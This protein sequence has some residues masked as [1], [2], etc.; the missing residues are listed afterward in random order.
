M[1]AIPPSAPPDPHVRASDGSLSSYRPTRADQLRLTEYPTFLHPNFEADAFAHAV[2]NGEDYP[3]PAEGEAPPTGA[4]AGGTGFMKGLVGENGLGDVSAA[5]ARLNFGIEDLNRQLKG[6][7]TKHH[8]SLL[9]QA[10]SLGGLDNDLSEVRRGLAEVEGGVTRLQRKI[11]TP[12]Q[13]LASSL[14]LLT[15]LRRAASLARRSQRFMVLARRLEA[16]MGEIDGAASEGGKTERGERVGERR[17]RAM[18]E[19]ALTLAE[20]ETLVAA[21]EGVEPAEDDPEAL[22]PIRSLVAVEAAIPAVELSRQHVV[23][24]METSVHRGLS[25]LDHPLLASSLQTA[26]NLLVLPSLVDSLL[27]DL[28]DLVLRS[29]KACFD[30]ASLSREVGGKD[31]PVNAASAFVYKSRTRNEP[32]QATMPQWSAVFWGRLENLVTDLGSVCIKVYTLEKVLR[33]KKDQTTQTS[34]LDDAMTVLDNKPSAL[35]WTTLAQ[36]FETQAKESARSSSFIQTTLSTGYP[37]LLRLFQEFFSKIAVHTDTVYTLAQQ[38]TETVLVLRAIQPFET[39]YL[40]RSTNRLTEA[41]TS[42]FSISSSLTPSFSARPPTVPTANEGL[43]TARSIVNELDAA[44]FDPLLV[45]AVAKGASRAVDTFVSRSEG[46]IVHDHAAMSLL[47]P[48]ATPSQHQNADLTSSLYHLWLPLERALADHTDSVNEI[49]RPSVD[50]TRSV[51]LGIINP[52]ILS[53]RRE[54]ST[55]LSRMH[56]VDYSKEADSAHGHGPM[57]VGGTSSYMTDLV[58]KL[59]LVKDEILRRT[60]SATWPRSGAALDLA[61]FTVQTFLLHAS[62][63]HPLSEAGKL[64]LTSDTTALEFAIS[65]YLAGH[66]L[67]L[68]SMGDQ[69]KALRAFRPL[70]FLDL[71][72]LADPAQTADVPTLILVQHLL[73]RANVAAL[74]LPNVLHGRTEAEYVRWLNEHREE[75]RIGMVEGVV[76]RWEEQGKEGGDEADKVA[77]LV[78]KVLE[79]VAPR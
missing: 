3:P 7:V 13:S 10:A 41:V 56:R 47:G 1:P 53:I 64:K 76:R 22:L 67:G 45:K 69:F 60:A 4:P 66:G 24:E 11:A 59:A 55:L 72:A 21:G 54:Y 18:A 52:L 12:H 20:I 44:R 14:L 31:G 79:R 68:N 40:T 29:V 75:E 34:F 63:V 26:H 42:A 16:Q 78:R 43:T 71:A 33:L 73:A 8:S 9:L 58:D 25:D 49:L 37:R 38:S 15:R 32:T 19:A 46:L 2:L 39:L 57:S 35:F 27:A 70:L 65:Q 61:R 23:Q 6:E 77:G 51:Y 28:N 48:L 30:M 74:P 5:L 17:E 36:A 50:R 62:L